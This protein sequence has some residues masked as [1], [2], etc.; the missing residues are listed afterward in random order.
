MIKVFDFLAVGFGSGAAGCAGF[1]AALGGGGGGGVLAEK[2]G[3]GTDVGLAVFWVVLLP[4]AVGAAVPHLG[5]NF[6]VST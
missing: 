2:I 4:S 5:Q 6:A 3:G 1:G